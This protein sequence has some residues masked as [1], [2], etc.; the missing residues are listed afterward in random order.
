MNKKKKWVKPRVQKIKNHGFAK[1]KNY[2][3]WDNSSPNCLSYV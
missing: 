1:M 3:G 2:C